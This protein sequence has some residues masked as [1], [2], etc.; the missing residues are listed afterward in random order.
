[1]SVFQQGLEPGKGRLYR[2]SS[3]DEPVDFA[4]DSER[5][6]AELFDFYGIAWEY[7]PTTFV[8]DTAPDGSLVSAFTPD[9]Y[10]PDHDLFV[11]VTT[12]RQTLVTRKNKKVRRL[13]ELHPGIQVRVLYR[14]DLER[15]FAKH[16]A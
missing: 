3:A 2:L 15:M 7:E 4:H 1:M 8:L 6:I 10:L 14:S 12:L 13:R 16:A 11:E 9:F 5:R